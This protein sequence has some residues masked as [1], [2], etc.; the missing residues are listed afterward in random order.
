MRAAESVSFLVARARRSWADVLGVAAAVIYGLPS[1]GYPFGVD[2]PIHWYLARRLLDGEMPYVSGVSTKPPGVFVVHAISLLLFGDH[3]WSIRIV[4]LGF[5]VATGA[6]IATF[7]A[8]RSMPDGSIASMPPRRPGELGAAAL[9]VSLL[10]YTY[11]GFSDTAHPELWQGF[12]MLLSGWVIVRAPDGRVS[13][14]RA[15]AAGAVACVAVTFKHVAALTG[16]LGGMAVV[17]LALSRRDAR[18]ALRGAASYTAGVAA[19]LV[20]LIAPFWL[21]GT[22]DALWTFMVDF[23]LDYAEGAGAR[24]GGWPRWLKPEYGLYAVVLGTL[25]LITGLAVVS[26]LRNRRERAVGGWIFWLVLGAMG[27]VFIQK[28]VFNQWG[29]SY[30][31]IAAV[32][33]LALALVWALR[34]VFPRRVLVP[35]AVITLLGAAAFLH[36]PAWNY[37]KAWSYRLEWPSFLAYVRGEQSSDEYH[38]N[39]KNGRFGDPVRLSRVSAFINARSRAGD[40]LCVDGF[41]AHLYQQTGLRCPSRFMI[42]DI[43]GRNRE[44]I[45]EYREMME[46][47]PPTFFVTFTDRA[48]PRQLARQ[49]YTRHDVTANGETYAVMIR[50]AEE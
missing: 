23:I 8:R 41:I 30:H 3:T 14:K 35:Y 34:C 4:D 38:H 29:F 28:R 36:A 11:W 37:N 12:F 6:I 46:E 40:T 9:A 1:L 42:G 22:L 33:F 15:F 39:H 18:G 16:V 20:L 10:Y 27:S 13:L 21:T 32:P 25:A 49:G 19:V 7:R 17:L 5:V 26:A 50:R 47:T 24:R 2:H 48:R 45:A 43:V 44:F 31:F